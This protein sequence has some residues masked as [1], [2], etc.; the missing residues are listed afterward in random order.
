DMMD[1]RDSDGFIAIG[2]H[3][4]GIYTAYIGGDTI[5]DTTDTTGNNPNNIAHNLGPTQL[6]VQVFPNPAADRTTFG[7]ELNEKSKVVLWI[8]DRSGRRI[9]EL[10]NSIMRKGFHRLQYDTSQLGAGIYLY[11]LTTETGKVSGKLVVN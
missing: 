3:G 5:A 7:F 10:G 1:Y 11:S 8:Y 2:T 6:D 9:A 4:A